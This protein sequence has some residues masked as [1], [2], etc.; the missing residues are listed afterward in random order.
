MLDGQI[1]RIVSLHVERMVSELHRTLRQQII[2][3][4]KVYFQKNEGTSPLKPKRKRILPC[5]KP[6]CRN[7]SKGPRFHYLCAEHRNASK[8]D[9]EEWR[10]RRAE[11]RP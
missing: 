11:Q 3:E 4:I 6:G 5:I 1:K 7:P 8:R 9:Y 2:E 10:A